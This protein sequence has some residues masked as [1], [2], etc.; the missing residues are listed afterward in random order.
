MAM[1]KGRINRAGKIHFSDAALAIWEEGLNSSMT[2]NQKTAWER[3]FK[4]DVFARIVQ[5]LHRLGWT[6]Q[7]GTYIF[8][9]NDARYC[10]KGDLQADLKISGRHIELDFFQNV[11]AP[12]RPDHGGRYQY[13]QEKHMPYLLRIEMERTRRRIR[14]YL[15]NVFTGYE[16]EPPKADRR[17]GATAIEIIEQKY[18]DNRHFGPEHI[19]DYHRRAADGGRIE[20]G[21][22]VWFTDYKGRILAGT[23]YTNGGM[24]LVVTGRYDFHNKSNSEIYTRRPDNLRIKRNASL[25][26]TRLERE[27]AKATEAMKFERAAVLRDILFPGGPELFVVWHKEHKA[28]HCAGFSGYTADKI[29]AGRFTADEVRAWRHEPNEVIALIG[30]REA[31]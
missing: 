4:R 25:R 28:Y 21:A 18:R 1:T 5:T 12:E 8:T 6:T 31:A 26:R 17:T 14:E 20:H 19:S 13:D 10:T 30:E 7:V 27:L 22:R 15:L 3:Q 23:A 9:G 11:N 24:W 2:W 29:K 16:F